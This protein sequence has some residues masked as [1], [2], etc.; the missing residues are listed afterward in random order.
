MST[1]T[2]KQYR[3]QQ[4]QFEV[5][6]PKPVEAPQETTIKVQLECQGC[7]EPIEYESFCADCAALVKANPF[8]EAPWD[9]EGPFICRWCDKVIFQ[10]SYGQWHHRATVATHCDR[11]A[12][13]K[14]APL[15]ETI[16]KP[17]PCPFCGLEPRV[18][19][20]RGS[21]ADGESYGY[22]FI[23]CQKHGS[24]QFVGVHADSHDEC[25]AAWNKRETPMA[26]WNAAK[27]SR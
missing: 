16:G 4:E 3:K 19:E 25:L 11:V 24:N 18:G 10:G 17:L 23:E 8:I 27:G 13:P 2:M 1:M 26:A 20:H 6:P 5:T 15:S 7:R 14:P 22:S 21:D 9:I 12:E